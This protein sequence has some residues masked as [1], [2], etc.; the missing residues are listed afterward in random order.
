MWNRIEKLVRYN[1]NSIGKIYSKEMNKAWATSIIG[2]ME[3]L[4][5][6]NSLI[7]PLI[8]QHNTNLWMGICGY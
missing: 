5:K 2:R 6:F 8:S 7:S 3:V 1:C 4:E